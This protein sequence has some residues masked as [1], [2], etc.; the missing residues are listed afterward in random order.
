MKVQIVNK[1]EFNN[2]QYQTAGA[3][4]M[5]LQA[6]L[7]ILGSIGGEEVRKIVILKPLER[8]LIPTGL[9]VA[10][11]D[12]YE[13]QIRP[14]SGLAYKQGIT[15]LNSPGT[16]DSDYRGEVGVLLVNLSDTAVSIKHGERIAQAVFARAEQ[17]ELDPVLFLDDT[18][19]GT[20]GF[21]HT[22]K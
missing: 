19:R 20:G 13:M 11:E 18:R 10:I 6:N 5:D 4:G 8:A 9:Y 22:G 3:A 7:P 17:A 16:I 14:R 12:G 15:V 1:S 2:P 21:G